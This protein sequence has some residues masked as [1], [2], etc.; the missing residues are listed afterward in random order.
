MSKQSKFGNKK[1]IKLAIIGSVIL[2]SAVVSIKFYTTNEYL[3]NVPEGVG[4]IGTDHAHSNFAV[5]LDWNFIDFDLNRYD[6][7]ANA[8]DYIFMLHDDA[9]NVIHRHAANATMGMFFDS[10][11][12]KW[13]DECFVLSPDTRNTKGDF[14]E[15]LEF[16]NEGD[17]KIRIFVNGKLN[18][19][20]H[21][22]IPQDFDSILVTFDNK[23]GTSRGYSI[24]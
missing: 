2:I 15:R 1:Y 14:F 4:P 7:Y 10:F 18:E 24:G 21:R 9:Y 16:C 19:M 6:K 20:G 13:T 5:I 22:Y 23:T 17:E 11:G 12:I 8:N 3:E